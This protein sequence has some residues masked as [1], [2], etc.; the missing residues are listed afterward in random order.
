MIGTM[1]SH[2]KIL[3]KLGEGGMGV[4]YKAHDTR[5]DRIVA[6]KFLPPR[7]S[8]GE[9][10]VQR[11]LQEA[12]AAAKLHH[13][14]I[15]TVFA[16]EDGD[17]QPFIVMEF[18]E[19]RTLQQQIAAGGGTPADLSESTHI[20]TQVGEA[21]REAHRKGI[22]HRDIKPSNIMITPD[23]R[24]K[25]M[26]FGLARMNMI[27]RDLTRTG[28][29]L[30]TLH[31]MSPE[32]LQG[33]PV[34]QRS[35]IFSFG[36]VLYEMLTGK[37]PFDAE[38]QAALLYAII[39]QDPVSADDL[40]ASVPRALAE[41]V[42]RC[43]SKRPEDR[44]PSMDDLLRDLHFTS[45]DFTVR[46]T[47]ADTTAL[48][49]Q[50][51]PPDADPFVGR[52]EPLQRM[53]SRLEQAILGR[54]FTLFL[55]G[56][57][58]VGKSRLM[59]ILATEARGKGM[60][61][62]WGRCLFR[63]EGV[64]Y[65]A[66]VSAFKSGF[67]VSEPQLVRALSETA[68]AQ[69]ISFENRL[70]QL[71]SFFNIGRAEA[72]LAN[73]EQLWDSVLTALRVLAGKHPI[74]VVI[75]DLQWADRTTTG[76]FAF[77]SRNITESRILLVGITRP[78]E[79]SSERDVSSSTLDNCVR[80]LRI[81]SLADQIDI[82]RLSHDETLLLT[83]R[84]LDDRD[85]EKG[86]VDVVHRSTQG[87]PLFVTE[88]VNLLKANEAIEY[89]GTSWKARQP[90]LETAIPSKL[91][92]G[93]LQRL[94]SLSREE[95]R[96]LE[97]A[98]CDGEYFRSETVAS[99][100]NLDR[101]TLL[102]LLQSLEKN[103]HLIRH[104]ARR[105]RFDCPLFRQVVYEEMLIEL[106]EEYHRMIGSWLARTYPDSEEHAPQI[107]SHLLA[108]G[109]QEEALV[110]LVRAAH[111]AR[112]LYA[113]DEALRLYTQ[114]Q[115]ILERQPKADNT[116][117]MSVLEGLADVLTS[118]GNIS[119][120]NGLYA[121]LLDRARTGRAYG[122]EAR[123]L[124]K[125]ADTCRVLGMTEE[126]VK[127]GEAAVSLAREHGMLIEE[128]ASLN[129]LGFIYSNRI[130][131]Y[132]RALE[133]YTMA[134]KHAE[135]AGD[136][137]SQATSLSNIGLVQWHRG[138]Y[139]S[140]VEPFERALAIQ[141]SIGDMK[142][143][144]IT[145]NFAGLSYHRLGEYEKAL[146]YHNESL[147]IKQSITDYPAIPGSLNNIGE[148][149]RDLGDTVK[150]VEYH[151]KGLALAREQRNPGA[152]CDNLR[153]LAVDYLEAGD[154]S[155]SESH[156]T[157]VLAL[158]REKGLVWYET[159]AYIVLGDIAAA[160]GDL[161]NAVPYS[162]QAVRS[163]FDLNANEL[164]IEALRSRATVVGLEGN[165]EESIR[166]LSQAITIAESVGHRLFLWQMYAALARQQAA[167]RRSQNAE[168]SFA[169]ARRLLREGIARFNDAGL[170]NLYLNSK[171]VKEIL[172]SNAQDVEVP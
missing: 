78:G 23:H 159:R 121:R 133:L 18:V 90:T 105:Y 161:E 26:D 5:L 148:V 140:T 8:S 79:W 117:I 170:R 110:Y 74:L 32:Q 77:L 167:L 164:K 69:G 28:T 73:K 124:Y 104:E 11:F 35:D 89:D 158:A 16:L 9:D 156:I 119:D 17:R 100:L 51:V 126:A 109:Q 60:P 43:L 130:A 139:S 102:T 72:N 76:L 144:A 34:D 54:G 64:P 111:R 40:N 57:A 115:S 36:V 27:G 137:R 67:D 153:D 2:Y 29:V 93:V 134:L 125:L 122:A 103:H 7:M 6:L 38:Y 62:L 166:L 13:P 162:Q 20:A 39:N 98:S 10:H 108:S 120:A 165:A 171:K 123:A 106:R 154:L 49:I 112:E 116:L 138:E 61:V 83:R 97:V 44:Y 81:E 65:H 55:T 143:L 113:T 135:S 163:A 141:R 46:R 118:L 157:K 58:G 1:V 4:V 12:R 168:E 107:A 136:L 80:Q 129:T 128:I 146:S 87:N 82:P 169:T 50:S 96:V 172:G 31:Y 33:F 145:L 152:E 56:E 15:C 99:C 68:E 150:A 88:V 41:S 75:D 132:P 127:H 66:F 59:R 86:I 94:S 22:I 3:E 14:N 155:S 42:S 21:L 142:G 30:G 52:S 37:R 53:R 95:H 48:P 149:Y 160:R 101:L 24:A 25:V 63:E 70:A 19:G 151:E 131:D 91:R 84:L 114:A 85:V 71:N 92:D 45:G 147:R 47:Q